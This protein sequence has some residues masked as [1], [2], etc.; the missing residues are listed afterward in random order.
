MRTEFSFCLRHTSPAGKT[1]NSARRGNQHSEGRGSVYLS[2]VGGFG[3]G[4]GGGSGAAMPA[5]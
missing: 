3:E 1:S 5:I 2:D 4:L